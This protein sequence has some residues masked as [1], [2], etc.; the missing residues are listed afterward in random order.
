MALLRW[1]VRGGLR[2]LLALIN[3]PPMAMRRQQGSDAGAYPSEEGSSDG[4][5]LAPVDNRGAT[6]AHPC[7]DPESGAHAQ[8]DQRVPAV[9][10]RTPQ[11][12]AAH[13][14][15]RDQ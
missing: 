13:L 8:T 6:A 14:W 5:A 4:D 15:F 10:A 7:R 9:V 1:C 3:R 11:L 2:G 12:D